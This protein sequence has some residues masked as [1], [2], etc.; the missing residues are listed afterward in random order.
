MDEVLAQLWCGVSHG[1]LWL[2]HLLQAKRI[3]V[4]AQQRGERIWKSG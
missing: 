4:N 3:A 2:P 1:L